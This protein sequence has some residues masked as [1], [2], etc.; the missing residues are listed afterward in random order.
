[1]SS[2]RDR[3]RYD[4]LRRIGCIACRKGGRFS[5]IDVH[6]LVDRGTRKHSG[7]NEASLP[8]CPHHHRNQPPDGMRPSEAYRL[9]GPTLRSHKRE[10]IERYG[11]ERELLAEVN[12]LI[13]RVS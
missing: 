7:G 10:F 6:H 8:L 12:S 9:Y 2:K 5:Q 1:M 4:Q 3:I 11:N 13:E